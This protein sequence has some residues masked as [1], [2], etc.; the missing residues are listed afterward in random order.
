M[1]K[2]FASFFVLALC[3][4]AGGVLAQE[5]PEPGLQPATEKLMSLILGD[6]DLQEQ[7]ERSIELGQIVNS[8][9]DTNPVASLEDYYRFIDALVT[10]PPQNIDTGIYDGKIRVSM[11]GANYCNWNILDILSFSYFLVDRQLTTDPRGQIQFEN[12]AF[13]SWMRD[14]AEEWGRYL[15]TPAS[16]VHVPDFTN[17]PNFGDW[18]CPPD[19]GYTTFQDFF[20]R[21]LCAATFPTGSRPVQ[22]YDDPAT[23]VSIGDSTSAG[24]WPIS[25]NGKLVT[26]YDGV[27]QGGEVIKGQL[28]SDVADFIIGK[29]G[30]T[31][32]ETFGSIDPEIF[33]RGTWTHQF[34]NVNNYHRLHV[35]V[36]GKIVYLRHFQSGVRMKSG[37]AEA[38]R[39]E[40]VSHYDPQ[41]TADWQFGQTRMV[42]GIETEDHGTVVISPMG[43][44]QVS[45]I[46]K[47]DWVKENAEADKGWEFANFAFGGSDFVIIFEEQADFVL[48]AKTV[49]EEAPGAGVSYATSLQGEKYGCFGGDTTCSAVPEVPP[50]SPA[51][52]G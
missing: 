29:E 27:S 9:P 13:S 32:L 28:Y 8:N 38:R 30:E 15:E 7:L 1:Y 6:P 37:W 43:M 2:R 33:N 11:D 51:D 20:T 39:P 41:D 3:T 26:T 49:P 44:A 46:V 14:I 4:S 36:A 22:G 50:A 52:G 21:E 42:I 16:A 12:D 35:P 18:Y 10:Y 17:D 48:T 34:L 47:R 31:V 24:W 23:V 45:S 40:E 25:G 19:T 5:C